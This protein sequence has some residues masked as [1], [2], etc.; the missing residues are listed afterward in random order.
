[1]QT[2]P[3]RVRRTV[4]HLMLAAA[5]AAVILVL[6]AGMSLAVGAA[7]ILSELWIAGGLS[8][9]IDSAGQAARIASDA[10]GNVAVV[11]GPSGG[12]DMAVTSYTADGAFRW[13][14]TVSP[15]VGTFQG[16]WVTAA[17][18]GD[19]IAVGHNV[20]SHGNAIQ[21]T[22]VRFASDGRLLW[23]VD[24]LVGF[25]PT[26]GRLLVDANGNAYLAV[27]GRGTGAFVQKYSPSGALLWSR[28]DSTSGGYAIASSLALSPDGDVAV[29]S[30]VLGG[31]SWITSVH[32]ATTG[33][34][35]WQ[36]V[37]PEGTAARDVVMD[38]AHVYVTGQGATGGGT[39][40]L[41]YYLTV[42]AY[43][44]ATGARLW[45]T[46]KK[47]ADAYD[48]AG[49][50][51]SLAPDGS[52][53]V[54]G[55]T[56][57]GFLDWYTV[58]FETT[59][60]VRWEAVRDG[61]LNTDE[62]P[63]GVLVL[64]DGTT[65]V[66]GKGG[67]NLP[68]GYIP[69]VTA[70]YSSNGELLWEAFSRMATVWA[71]ALPN[72]DVCATGGYD[73]FITCW[74][75][76]GA[77]RAVMSAAPSTGVAPLLVSFDGSRSTTPNGTI[78]SWAWS[79][80]DGVF[81]TGPLITHLYTNPGTYAASLTVTDSTG[82]SSVATGSIVANPSP[83]AA[84]SGL[85]ASQSGTLIVLTWQDNSSNETIFYI[86][87]CQGV[88][89]TDFGSFIATQWPNVPSYTDYSAVTGQNYRYRVRAY[90]SGGYSAYSNIA[91]ILVGAANQPPT[92]VI[93]AV[94]TTGV[95]PLSVVFNGSGSSDPDGTIATWAWSF[96]DD[97]SGSG[98]TI[99][100]V[101]PAAGF[102]VAT[103]TVTDNGGASNT[104]SVTISVTTGAASVPTAPTTLAASSSTR[105]RIKLTWI[106]TATN[107]TSI[108]V[109]R[110]SGSTCTGFVPVAQLA[111][112]AESWTDT[113]VKSRSTYRYR[114]SASNAAGRS[115]YSNIASATAR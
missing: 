80:G 102:Y 10:S 53:V 74:R 82:A 47:P 7:T 61:G 37:A 81:G 59:G 67:P 95:A 99:T 72:G 23:R 86:E 96:G 25:F 21:S 26:V 113:R 8:A 109:Q 97:T 20:D 2:H 27:S 107:A 89:C 110:C 78:T 15:S 11:S 4:H 36:V 18:N 52:L 65:V 94:P 76:S 66:T 85:T 17:P 101:Y 46:D 14:S 19:V 70:G 55:Q 68:G 1:M 33:A 91:S 64:E 57:R 83:P 34:R 40:A 98:P 60:A 44:R 71:T 42:V 58:A 35:K 112:T 3:R 73:A 103:V 24:P 5:P 29:T 28:L 84:P 100:H 38:A 92:A 54:T 104:T 115:P 51:M 22:L 111:A 62:I 77:V 41:A 79:F 105:A 69:G 9:G 30:S 114:V 93:S 56:N 32:D 63:S 49:L 75:V 43:D 90:N 13:R 12:R 48:A 16:D 50:R 6:L 88:G 106:N 31:A 45:R 87:R 39:P 108:T